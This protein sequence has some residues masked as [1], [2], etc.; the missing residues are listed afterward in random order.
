MMFLI[1]CQMLSNFLC[2]SAWAQT[3]TKALAQ[4]RTLNSLSNH[5]P[6][7]P[8]TTHRKLFGG[9]QAQQENKIWYVGFLQSKELVPTVLT[10]PPNF[11]DPKMFWIQNFWTEFFLLTFFFC[12]N[13]YFY[14]KLFWDPIFLT[15]SSKSFQVE[16]FKPQACRLFKFGED[17]ESKVPSLT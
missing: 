9:L 6:P 12:P 16:H 17:N 11:F 1:N 13:S 4:S 10:P 8:T 7:P 3:K 2:C 14:P 5:P 15:Q